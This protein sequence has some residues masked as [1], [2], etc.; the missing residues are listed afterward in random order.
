MNLLVPRDELAD[1]FLDAHARLESQYP[2]G[3]H[4]VGI[5]QSHVSRLVGMMLDLRLLPQRVTDQRDEAIETDAL[6]ATEV[7]VST[8]PG[9]PRRSTPAQPGRR[10]G[11]R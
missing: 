6:A 11:S 5:G 2:P 8:V 3:M 1:P 7:T 9:L 4:Q 10:P